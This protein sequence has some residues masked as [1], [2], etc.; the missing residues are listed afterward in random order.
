M[1]IGIMGAM[2]Q[3][4]D[5]IREQMTNISEVEHG[6]RRYYCG[7]INNIN[8]VLVFS[9]CGKVAASTTA[10]S[11]ITEF[12]VDQIIFT[13]VAGAVSP[14]LNIGDIVI[15]DELYQHDIDARPLFPRYEIPLMGVAYFKANAVLIKKAEEACQR[16]FDHP[17]EAISSTI[18]KSF[19]IHSPKHVVG[20]IT[21]GD[22]FIT[23]QIQTE[24]LRLNQPK[25]L[26]V[27]ME[28]AAV[29]QVCYDYNI[30]FVIIRTI[31]DR[32]DHEAHIDFPRFIDDI[33]KHYA[34][35]VIR[36]IFAHWK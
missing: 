23:S 31:S 6:N 34:E 14:D 4:V 7:E 28:G 25:T 20:T 22:Q 8:V 17:E 35:H 32:A 13:G 16:L 21:C 12:K 11:L 10:T 30:P 2:P 1:K 36:Y 15:S 3:E 26:A 19:G 33:A 9:R 18:L 5:I 29:A 27:E 24:A